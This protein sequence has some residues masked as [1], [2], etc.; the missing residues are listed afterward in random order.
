M[1]KVFLSLITVFM[2]LSLSLV[3][4]K[5]SEATT[6]E[7]VDGVQIRTDGNNGLKWQANIVNYKEGNEYGFL[8][9]QGELES[10]TVDTLAVVKKV[11]EG[12]TLEETT[13]EATMVNFPKSAATQ[14][15]SVVAYV[16]DGENYT[17]SNVVVRNLSEVAVYAKNI[18]EGEFVDSIVEYAASNYMSSYKLGDIVFVNN[19]VYETNPTKL[20]ETFIADWNEKFGT[21]FTEYSYSDWASSAKAGYGDGVGM[22]VNGDTDC[23]GTNAYE[24]FITDKVTSA[25]WKWLLTF[26]LEETNTKVHP[27]RQIN[28]LLNNGSYSDSYGGGLQQFAHLSRSLQ[29][30]FDAKGNDVYSSDIDVVIKDLTVYNKLAAYNTTVYA[31][32]QNFVEKGNELTLAPLSKEGYTFDG[33]TSL[34]HTYNGSYVVT[35][36]SAVL[37]PSFTTIKYDL[38]YLEG[39]N[40]VESKTYTVEDYIELP[41]VEREGYDFLGWYDNPEFEGNPVTI[42]EK[43]NTGDKTFYLNIVESPKTLVT[44]DTAG[45]YFAMYPSVDA[46]IADF[47]ADYN[48]ARGKSHT[49]ESFYALGSW[50]EISDASL[51]LYNANY[52]AKW[53]WLVNYIA[54]VASSANKPAYEKFYNFTSQSE[55]NADNSNHIY[56]IAYELRGWVGQ[57]KYTKNGSFVTADYSSDSVKAAYVEAVKLPNTALYDEVCALPTPIKENHEF[58]GWIDSEGNPVTKFPGKDVAGEAVTYTATWKATYVK[59]N[60]TFDANGGYLPM[61]YDTNAKVASTY[62][63]VGGASGTY[64]C[65]TS[66]T[67][68]NSLRWQYKVLLQY[69]SKVNAYLVVCLDAAKASANNAA[70]NAGVTWTHALANA[71]SNITTEYTQGQYIK[72]EETPTVGD[73]N[74]HYVVCNSQEALTS[75]Q[76]PTSYS[77]SFLAPTPFITPLREGYKFLG[78]KSSVDDSIVTEYPGYFQNLGTITYTAIWKSDLTVNIEVDLNGGYWISEEIVVA[79]L[80]EAAVSTTSIVRFTGNYYG[81][82]TKGVLLGSIAIMPKSSTMVYSHR[83][84]LKKIDGVYQIV[85]IVSSGSKEEWNEDVE[86][87]LYAAEGTSNINSFKSKCS[88]GDIIVFDK[89]IDNLTVSDV[90]I[91]A[92]LY[93]KAQYDAAKEKNFVATVD[94]P[95]QIAYEFKHSS[96]KFIGWYDNPEGTGEKIET[97]TKS[98]II[99]AVWSSY[100]VV[101]YDT[102]PFT[103]VGNSIKLN[104]QMI[105]NTT[106]NFVWESKNT[107]VATVDQNG[108][109]T[110]IK[111]GTV[112][113]YVYD[114]VDPSINLSVKISVVS[115]GLSELFSILSDAHNNQIFKRD[116]LGIG[117]GTPVYYANIYGSVSKIMFNQSLNIDQTYLNKEVESNTGDYYTLRSLEFITVHYTGNMAKNA[118][119]QANAAYFVGDNAVSIHYT[120]GNDGV[121]QALPHNLG[122]MHAGDGDS[123]DQVGYFEWIKTGVAYDNCDLLNVEF[124]ASDDFYFE[125][126][127]KKTS[128]KLPGTW[129]YKSRNTN[130]TYNSNGTISSL[131]SYTGTKFTNRTPE[132]FFNDWGF[133]VKV[134]NGEYY[135]G[136]TW[137]CY[138]QV[139]EGRICATGGNLNSIGIESCVDLGSDLWYTWQLTAKL[140]AKLCY[141]NG[142]GFE[143][144]RPHHAYTA[145]DCPQPLLENNLEIWDMFIELVKYEYELLTKFSN[146]TITFVSNNPDYISNTGRIIKYPVKDTTVSYTLT[147]TDKTTGSSNSVTYFSTIPGT[148]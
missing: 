16:Y 28:A 93:S 114:S 139:H 142:L 52:K 48:A 87:V 27:K 77:T 50:D 146:Y 131:S 53:T 32:D 110:G 43:G 37:T 21:D 89:Q 128:I 138:S 42:I 26:F 75:Y 95:Y 9:A 68:N 126:N 98:G 147:L 105:G 111:E 1:K 144:I 18:V 5:A 83:I 109:V 70:T 119:A 15:I 64:L 2:V 40:V 73:D 92:N 100:I 39:E 130:H 3:L 51:F 86:Y 13:M 54:K 104:A 25:K 140:V 10:V 45:G 108:V 107:K 20:E 127:G 136:T 120:T 129:N 117:A 94:A 76:Y 141:D 31:K 137:W 24:F 125:I 79:N 57:A 65:D 11:V 49:T 30:F 6:V 122:A 116:S 80:E 59:V 133:P 33:Y 106:G 121:Y 113:I 67:K 58:L 81:D 145:K 112:D 103:E 74:L 115:E 132:S 38:V 143:R 34:E 4:V 69:D 135:M 97:I 96:L 22:T 82:Y 61:S 66:V 88:L 55:L 84:G 102:D 99:Y 14:D 62:D 44:F 17:Y 124:T 29:N 85:Q 12:V 101:S 47:L 118:D 78:W 19:A 134:V 7:L 41:V 56:R 123:V 23:S 91:T 90:S 60:A 72:F 36:A 63:N 71:S 148:K 46:A 8:F 35:E